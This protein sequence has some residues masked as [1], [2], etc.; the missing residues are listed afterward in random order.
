MSRSIKYN[1]LK[2][3]TC[4]LLIAGTTFQS[5]EVAAQDFAEANEEAQ[6][7][8]QKFF[9]YFA[10]WVVLS[11]IHRSGEN[12]AAIDNIFNTL[13]KDYAQNPILQ[14]VLASFTDS[15]M[16]QYSQEF[17]RQTGIRIY[18]VGQLD[19]GEGDRFEVVLNHLNNSL[20]AKIEDPSKPYIIVTNSLKGDNING[21][22]IKTTVTYS[23]PVKGA[24]YKL[25]RT[26]DSNPFLASLVTTAARRNDAGRQI[27]DAM[28]A[29][30]STLSERV[31]ENYLPNLLIESRN[32][33][34][35]DGEEIQSGVLENGTVTLSALNKELEPPTKDVEW[36]ISPQ[37]GQADSATIEGNILTFPIDKG[38]DYAI[39]ATAGGDEVNVTLRISDSI[40]DLDFKKILE[41]LLLEILIPLLEEE[42]TRQ[43]ELKQKEADSLDLAISSIS[44]LEK[45][46]YPI[47]EGDGT[48]V[49]ESN[50]PRAYDDDEEKVFNEGPD[51]PGR[52]KALE[53]LRKSKKLK[54]DLAKVANLIGFVTNVVSGQGE[55][56]DVVLNDMLDNVG[57]LLGEMTVALLSGDGKEEA[58]A[59]VIDYLDKN[60]S[61]LAGED[62]SLSDLQPLAIVPTSQIPDSFDPNLGYYINPKIPYTDDQL[63]ALVKE[64]TDYQAANQ[65]SFVVVN[66]SQDIDRASF[67]ARVSKGAPEGFEG[68][69]YKVINIVNY[70]GSI[71]VDRFDDDGGAGGGYEELLDSGDFIEFAGNTEENECRKFIDPSGKIFKLPPTAKALRFFVKE[72]FSDKDNIASGILASFSIDNKRYS[73]YRKGREFSGYKTSKTD[74]PYP[75]PDCTAEGKVIIGLRVEGDFCKLQ[76]YFIEGYTPSGDNSRQ[77]TALVYGESVAFGEK[78]DVPNCL[79]SKGA[80]EFLSIARK[81][82]AIPDNEA[83]EIAKIIEESAA[84]YYDAYKKKAFAGMNSDDWFWRDL[85][86]GSSKTDYEK[87]KKSLIQHNIWLKKIHDRVGGA[88]QSQDSLASFLWWVKDSELGAL[89]L[90]DR[91]VALRTLASERMRGNI[92]LLGNNEEY[93]AIRLIN[94]VPPN[95]LEDFFRFLVSSK[96]EVDNSKKALIVA[97]NDE[98]DDGEYF[99]GDGNYGR[100]AYALIQKF[101]ERK[102]DLEAVCKQ[103]VE[104]NHIF[105]WNNQQGENIYK[106]ELNDSDGKITLSLYKEE[107]LNSHYYA[108]GAA[109]GAPPQPIR[110]L[111]GTKKLDPFDP[112]IVYSE[113]TI[114]ELQ[115]T[116]QNPIVMGPALLLHY[117]IAEDGNKQIRQV[118]RIVLDGIAVASG[119]GAIAAGAQGIVL[120]IAIAE[121]VV[122]VSDLGVT[123]FEEEI[124]EMEGGPEFL[125]TYHKVSLFANMLTLSADGLLKIH[126][127]AKAD[128]DILQNLMNKNKAI[129]ETLNRLIENISDAQKKASLLKVK[130]TLVALGV[131]FGKFADDWHAIS[132]VKLNGLGHQLNSVTNVAVVYASY[133]ASYVAKKLKDGVV[134]TISSLKGKTNFDDFSTKLPQ[135]VLDKIA[136]LGAKLELKSYDELV[137]LAIQIKTVGKLTDIKEVG[138]LFDDLTNMMEPSYLKAFLDKNID[139]KLLRNGLSEVLV[140]AGTGRPQALS[141]VS[142]WDKKLIDKFL[143]DVPKYRLADD[144]DDVEEALSIYRKVREQPENAWDFIKGIDKDSRLAKW[145]RGRFFVEV[146]QRGKDFEQVVGPALR[147]GKWRDKLK[148]LLK[149]KYKV[150]NLDDYELIEQ[151]QLIYKNPPG[152]YFIADQ[153]FVKYGFDADGDKFIDDLIVIE[154]KL[155]ESTR[156]TENQETAKSISEYLVRGSKIPGLPTGSQAIFKDN[157]IKWFK[158]HSDGVGKEI[159]NLTDKF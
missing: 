47:S 135:T 101:L 120:V 97:L 64:I 18:F 131:G 143:E 106:S 70:P 110:T 157:V 158:V 14:E 159:K 23:E 94:T 45:F 76:K 124:E 8:T 33:L 144:M 41:D 86:W 51:G 83:I 122:S 11:H 66:Y 146:T 10:D 104:N 103:I 20:K 133:G 148:A 56:R 100:F 73:A 59:I 140:K 40:L 32:K 149:D 44:D 26:N 52:K 62:V 127:L 69:S 21:Y 9:S 98:F 31:T 6:K 79:S 137:D 48:L 89:P 151:V 53:S 50:T 88:D 150:D 34:Y 107:Y 67:L 105:V 111:T 145:S 49:P 38:G 74:T 155:S 96:L 118:V 36:L 123:L 108:Y 129:G 72:E 92:N 54:V 121:L 35:K 134:T 42:L 19:F 153:V 39:K 27:I 43:E 30:I 1:I 2:W 152:D 25:D 3:A 78:E 132:K 15:Q 71:L 80:R 119:V 29:G 138:R 68:Q 28:L 130:N 84:N 112:I 65:G 17:F 5:F 7:D 55:E 136:S 91:I 75:Q 126:K 147:S 156:L 63:A 24:K 22:T 113:E 154:N 141:K 87:F 128:I 139:P 60:L 57:T 90:N 125:Q 13:L 109:G 116:K 12:A 115:L 77:T 114:N 82:N 37:G 81:N 102:Q 16:S 93:L 85:G 99:I 142:G 95:D 117:I 46:N 61:R 58:K 4:F